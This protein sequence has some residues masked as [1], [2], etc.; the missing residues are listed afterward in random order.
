MKKKS[1]V[2]N[3]KHLPDRKDVQVVQDN[4]LKEQN[5]IVF[6][7]LDKISFYRTNSAPGTMIP[8]H[9]SK[10]KVSL[11]S[12]VSKSFDERKDSLQTFEDDSVTVKRKSM[13]LL[14]LLV[15]TK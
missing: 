5:Q 3:K 7:R 8:V 12:Y 4:L 9:D 1:S 14:S 6:L 15:S 10:H 2:K 11:N 13:S